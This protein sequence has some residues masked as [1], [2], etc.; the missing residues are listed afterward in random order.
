MY[1]SRS[2]LYKLATSGTRGSSGL[3]WSNSEQ[4]LNKIEKEDNS[5]DKLIAFLSHYKIAFKPIFNNGGC[6]I[7][8]TAVDADD[9]NDLLKKEV[10]K[11]INGWQRKVASL[12]SEG[13][14][15][16]E[17]KNI[18]IDNFSYRMISLIQGSVLLAKTL[19][20]PEILINNVDFLISEIHQIKKN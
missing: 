16:G 7:L 14:G 20:K 2:L 13:I 11:T 10:I 8:N 6:A 15:K 18:D 12:L 1:L 3:G 17:I 4:I 19:N 5:V 9:G